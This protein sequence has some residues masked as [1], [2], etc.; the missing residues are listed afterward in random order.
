MKQQQEAG[1]DSILTLLL[2]HRMHF[3]AFG[4]L[5]NALNNRTPKTINILKKF[6]GGEKK[7]RLLILQKELSLK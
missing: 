2:N 4:Q 7:Q 3:C 1:I 6:G 5:K